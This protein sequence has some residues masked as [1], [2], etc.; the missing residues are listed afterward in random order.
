M[1]LKKGL[2]ICVRILENYIVKYLIKWG[3]LK[4]LVGFIGFKPTDR[5]QAQKFSQNDLHKVVS[6]ENR[7]LERL[8]KKVCPVN[9]DY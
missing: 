9:F 3:Y 2:A 1:I 6:E 4:Y 7:M 8:A 5:M